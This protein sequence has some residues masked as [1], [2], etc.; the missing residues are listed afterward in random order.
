N[1]RRLPQT[2][3]TTHFTLNHAEHRSLLNR[4]RVLTIRNL[5]RRASALS[6]GPVMAAIT[7][8][9][10]SSGERAPKDR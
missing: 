3:Y 9:E 2:S 7:V 1:P 4:N 5:T 6:N 8:K 10:Q